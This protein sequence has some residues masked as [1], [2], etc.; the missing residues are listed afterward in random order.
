LMLSGFR[1]HLLAD[2]A[3]IYDVLYE[4]GA[5]IE[6]ACWF[7]FR[8]YIWRALETERELALEALA[9]IAKLFEISRACQPIPMPERTLERAAKA[10]PILRLLDTWVEKHRDHVDPRGRLDKAIGYYDNQREALHRFLDDG[11]IRLD[12]SISEQQMRKVILGDHN[13]GAFENETGLRWYTTFRSLIASCIL[14]GLNPQLYLEQ[15]LRLAPHWP[16]TRLLELSPKYWAKTVAG[17]DER[18]RA[19]IRRPWEST[20]TVGGARAVPR[21]DAA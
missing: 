5:I 21:A 9:L 8:R 7:H 4:D 14:H 20:R 18:H 17:L 2:A 12:N 10:R 16:V 1:G 13:W 11:R 15:L 19:I 6:I 3:P